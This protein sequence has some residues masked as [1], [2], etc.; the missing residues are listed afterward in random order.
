MKNRKPAE[1]TLLYAMEKDKIFGEKCRRLKG[2]SILIQ[3]WKYVANNPG[4]KKSGNCCD[5]YPMK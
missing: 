5:G 1:N 3:V 2:E 4:N